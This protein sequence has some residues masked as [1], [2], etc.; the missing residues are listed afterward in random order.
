MG[1]SASNIHWSVDAVGHYRS[2]GISCGY[3]DN[4]TVNFDLLTRT[5]CTHY[6][7]HGWPLCHLLYFYVLSFVLQL[8]LD[9]IL[10]TNGQTTQTITIGILLI[11]VLYN[12][13]VFPV[14]TLDKAR[15]PKTE[16]L[17]T[18]E[19]EIYRQEMQVNPW[20]ASFMVSLIINTLSPY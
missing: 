16:F 17:R 20:L 2:L 13:T 4:V 1:P 11:F 9:T 3:I 15:P 6:T 7:W 14:I 10:G 18:V 19:K 5:Y 12:Q 8:G